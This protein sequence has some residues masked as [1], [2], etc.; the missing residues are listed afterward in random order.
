MKNIA[1]VVPPIAILIFFIIFLGYVR[2]WSMPT[3]YKNE[4][5]VDKP[6]KV[7][8]A[9]SNAVHDVSSRNF[10]VVHLS[11]SVNQLKRTFTVKCG[12]IDSGKLI[13]LDN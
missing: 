5:T 8:I 4:I 9:I 11:V 6:E 2:T 10:V 12:G 13:S 3:Q 7:P 1:A